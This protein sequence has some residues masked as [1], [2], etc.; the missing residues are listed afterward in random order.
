MTHMSFSTRNGRRVWNKPYIIDPNIVLGS[1]TYTDDHAITLEQT[2]YDLIMNSSSD[3][4]FTMSTFGAADIGKVFSIANINTGKLTLDM[5]TG[6]TIDDSNAAGTIYS[7]DDK[8]ASLKFRIVSSAHC[9]II[10]GNGTWT[11]T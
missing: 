2:G 8:I 6:K 11:T 10:G 3:K 9:Q 1:T 5:P 7:T 4:T